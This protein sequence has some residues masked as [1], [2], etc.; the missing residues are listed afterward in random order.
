MTL[1]RI[2]SSARYRVQDIRSLCFGGPTYNAVSSG[3]LLWYCEPGNAPKL[4]QVVNPYDEAGRRAQAI[5]MRGWSAWR[6]LEPGPMGHYLRYQNAQFQRIQGNKPYSLWA[7][8][9]HGRTGIPYD[10]IT[11]DLIDA[12][13]NKTARTFKK[14]F[15]T[16]TQNI[17]GVDF[18]GID[19]FNKIRELVPEI[20]ETKAKNDFPLTA[21]LTNYLQAPNNVPRL[22]PDANRWMMG[23]QQQQLGTIT[24]QVLTEEQKRNDMG[25]TFSAV[26]EEIRLDTPQKLNSC[27][28]FPSLHGLDLLINQ[29]AEFYGNR[30][31]FDIFARNIADQGQIDTVGMGNW[32]PIFQTFLR[33]AYGKL[34]NPSYQN[35]VPFVIG[36]SNGE[37][38]VDGVNPTPGKSIP[39]G[40]K[41]NGLICAVCG[42]RTPN[43]KKT[44]WARILSAGKQ[45]WDVD[46]IA[47]LIFNELFQLNETGTE[48]RGDGRGF[49]NTCGTCNRQFKGEKLWSPSFDLWDALIARCGDTRIN[50]D[51]FPWPGLD[52]PGIIN[53]RYAP[54]EGWRVYMTK[55]YQS[56]QGPGR[57]R[58]IYGGAIQTNQATIA[59]GIKKGKAVQQAEGM[60]FANKQDGKKPFGK[61][62]ITSV[63]LEAII[64]NRFALI[65]LDSSLGQR[66]I[67][68]RNIQDAINLVA[69]EYNRQI[70]VFP[71]V[72]QYI[73]GIS[74]R[75]ELSNQLGEATSGAPAP[76]PSESQQAY[77]EGAEYAGD[78]GSDNEPGSELGGS[79]DSNSGSLEP[80]PSK[81]PAKSVRQLEAQEERTYYD[82]ETQKSITSLAQSHR[83]PA[84]G[85][86]TARVISANPSPGPTIITE[87]KNFFGGLEPNKQTAEIFARQIVDKGLTRADVNDQ[88]ERLYDNITLERGKYKAATKELK[89]LA[90]VKAGTTSPNRRKNLEDLQLRAVKRIKGYSALIYMIEHFIRPELNSRQPGRKLSKSFDKRFQKN[91]APQTSG[92]SS[93]SSAAGVSPR[94]PKGKRKAGA[95]TGTPAALTGNPAALT[96]VGRRILR[97]AMD[98]GKC[99]LPNISN[100]TEG[101]IRFHNLHSQLAMLIFALRRDYAEG[102]FDNQVNMGGEAE[103][104]GNTH[105]GRALRDNKYIG[106]YINRVE[107]HKTRRKVWHHLNSITNADG[108]PKVVNPYLT[109][110]YN[111]KTT[112]RVD[113]RGTKYMP[114]VIHHWSNFIILSA[115]NHYCPRG[116]WK[117]LTNGGISSPDNTI[118]IRYEGGGGGDTA[119]WIVWRKG[120]GNIREIDVM[121]GRESV[122]TSNF[123][124]VA[125]DCGPSAVIKAIQLFQA[126]NKPR[127]RKARK[128]SGTAFSMGGKRTRKKRR[129]KKKT[130]RKRKYHKKTKGRKR[131]RK[132]RTRRK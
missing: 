37:E 56:Q 88:Q 16:E 66:I 12:L 79:Q 25:F 127:V 113:E 69:G 55:A 45:T 115:L 40:N 81:S 3:L 87:Y 114:G 121:N 60:S 128:K 24:I 98:S 50:H 44:N 132:K 26:G 102:I 109:E 119:H 52:S 59:K 53:G 67:N 11:D 8:L 86:S 99:E 107:A 73:S 29:N 120:L 93:S 131:R 101:A 74:K 100:I 49:L 72:S 41:S 116:G 82:N 57:A 47:N 84:R 27:I 125:G 76:A 96:G 42:C 118:Q 80:S 85:F 51:E 23:S 92:M 105:S 28:L 75:N 90:T 36:D 20:I 110:T 78:Y 17:S 2:L 10:D 64:L 129:K 48:I 94:K 91:T 117:F 30:V 34:G 61:P 130:R 62:L 31:N 54:A 97:T 46:H 95:L 21:A 58:D 123:H 38:G 112:S 124:R 32:K 68:S 70:S 15:S 9:I 4:C 35:K 111:S 19:L 18:I 83:S 43:G 77:E 14:K 33:D 5:A 7:N 39:P 71:A 22:N 6:N 104:V 126:R 122:E 106:P 103:L 63:R 13:G 89:K 108:T 1:Y 65:C